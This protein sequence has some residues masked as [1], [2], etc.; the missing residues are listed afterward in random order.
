MSII[1]TKVLY[2]VA[3][4]FVVKGDDISNISFNNKVFEQYYQYK[5]KY[6]Y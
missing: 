6:F 4:D 3:Q 5:N 2:K 1:H